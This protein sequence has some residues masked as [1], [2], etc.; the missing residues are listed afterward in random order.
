MKLTGK[1]M[2]VMT[3]LWSNGGLMT[4]TEI[5]RITPDRTWHPGSIF[6][7]M[8]S[9]VNKG[10]VVLDSH[11]PTGG[12]HA[13]VYKAIIT[14]EDYAVRSIAAMSETGLNIDFD[15]LADKIKNYKK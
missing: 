14:I 1:E 12:K 4:T 6:S 9:L 2:E 3:T 7:I 13:R 5:I 10:A 15:L 11:K 8:R